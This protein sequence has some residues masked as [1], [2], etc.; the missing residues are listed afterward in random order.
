M[1][2]FTETNTQNALVTNPGSS[3]EVAD[4]LASNYES[5]ALNDP[6]IFFHC[7]IRP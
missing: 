1:Q 6:G 2:Q 4:P 3:V 5:L 7:V